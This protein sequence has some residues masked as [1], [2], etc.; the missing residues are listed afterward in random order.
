MSCIMLYVTL[1]LWIYVSLIHRFNLFLQVCV[2][3]TLH[4]TSFRCITQHPFPQQTT[5]FAYP[6]YVFYGAT[7]CIAC[8]II[9]LPYNNIYII[10]IYICI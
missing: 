3:H 1:R 6:A 8:H 2:L 9:M 4:M 10:I 5:V 7:L